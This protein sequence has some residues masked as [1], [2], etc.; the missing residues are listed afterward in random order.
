MEYVYVLFTHDNTVVDFLRQGGMIAPQI[1]LI[2]Y[3]FLEFAFLWSG[4]DPQL[5][6]LNHI[7]RPP[8]LEHF[9]K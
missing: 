8:Y 9:N 1:R 2:Q 5:L 4:L 6:E 7:L 3:G